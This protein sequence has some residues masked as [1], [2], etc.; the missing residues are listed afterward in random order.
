MSAISRAVP[1]TKLSYTVRR[2]T[3][4]RTQPSARQATTRQIETPISQIGMDVGFVLVDPARDAEHALQFHRVPANQ[5]A[6][7]TARA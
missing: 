5:E 3:I 6:D 1:R 7:T 4:L 2:K